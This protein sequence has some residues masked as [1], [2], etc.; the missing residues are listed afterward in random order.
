MKKYFVKVNDEEIIVYASTPPVAI[1]RAVEIYRSRNRRDRI[2]EIYCD[3]RRAVD[4][5]DDENMPVS[6]TRRGSRQ[7]DVSKK[8]GG[9][10][11][12]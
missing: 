8:L 3:L 9:G 10:N 12:K 4:V 11:L 1:R 2:L 5:T 6:R 7:I